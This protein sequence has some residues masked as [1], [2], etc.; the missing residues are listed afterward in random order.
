MGTMPESCL[1]TRR[2]SS[3]YHIPY[4][5]YTY[6][7]MSGT[8]NWLAHD[9]YDDFT[10]FLKKYNEIMKP[11]KPPLQSIRLSDQ[12]REQIRYVQYSLN[13]EKR[14]G[15]WIKFFIRWQEAGQSL[16]VAR[17]ICY[18]GLIFSLEKYILQSILPCQ[19]EIL[20]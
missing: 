16:S 8:I 15:Y 9:V 12:V 10:M 1:S 3:I 19:S 14:A 20:S 17:T 18:A 7:N 6:N 11:N 13:A 5:V 2:C 4:Y